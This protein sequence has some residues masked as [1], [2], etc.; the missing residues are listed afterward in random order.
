MVLQKDVEL[1][2][3]RKMSGT[4]LATKTGSIQQGQGRIGQQTLGFGRQQGETSASETHTRR[5][6]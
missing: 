1:G 6:E 5:S 4:S 3:L 2:R